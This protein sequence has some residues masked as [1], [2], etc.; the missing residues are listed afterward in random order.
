M[1]P[2][3]FRGGWGWGPRGPLGAGSASM[4]VAALALVSAPGLR[5]QERDAAPVLVT[6]QGVVLDEVTKTP[7]VGAAVYLED[8]SHGALTDALGAFRIEG[9]PADSQTVVA[10]QF[11]YWE[12]AAAIN[13]PEAGAV[14][15][16]ELKPRPVLLDGVTAVTDNIQTMVRRLQTRRRSLPYQTRAFDQERLLRSR[17]VDALEFL[18]R[19]ANLERRPCPS[20]VG[21]TLAG[22]QPNGRLGGWALPSQVAG[23][24]ASQCIRRRGRVVSPRV[25]IDEVPAV[26]GVDALRNYPTTRIYALEVFSQGAE[27]RAYTYRFMQRMA[28]R[29]E[30]MIALGLWP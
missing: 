10:T 23:A 13:V 29:P 12:I 17:S 3:G 26:N 20:T 5:A 9:V 4:M 1:D 22:W 7:V 15:E 2:N 27:I 11:G 21:V 24:L 16:I 6:L 25:Y 18:W 19:E 30:A 28:E 14:I 8:E